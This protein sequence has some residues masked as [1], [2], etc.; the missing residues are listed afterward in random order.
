LIELSGLKPAAFLHIA[1]VNDYIG[2][3]LFGIFGWFFLNGVPCCCLR[4][5]LIV[6]AIELA[7]GCDVP[8]RNNEEDNAHKQKQR[9][10]YVDRIDSIRKLIVDY[11]VCRSVR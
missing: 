7:D 8:Q 5:H 11:P 6:A 9:Q 2:L 1:Q 10:S 3:I 4:A